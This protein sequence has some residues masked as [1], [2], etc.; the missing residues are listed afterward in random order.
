MMNK[1]EHIS[2]ICVDYTYDGLGLVRSESGFCVFV[3]DM[4]VGEAGDI[5]ITKSR[6]NYAYGRLLTRTAT[7][8][9]RVKPVCPLY[10]QC[11]GCQLQHMSAAEQAEFKQRHVQ[12]NLDTIASTK[13]TAEPVITMADPYHYR[14]KMQMP[15]QTDENGHLQA[16]FYRY[17]SHEIIPVDACLLQNEVTNAILHDLRNLIDQYHIASLIRHI[18]IKT[19]PNTSQAM[20]ALVLWKQPDIDLLPLAEQLAEAQPWVV[21]VISCIND[22]ET[23]V[24]WG[25]DE[26]TVYGRNRITDELMQCRFLISA[27][28]FYQVNSSQTAVL[29]QTALDAAGLKESDT[30]I[31][32][33]CGVGTIGIL[34][35]GRVKKVIGVE[36]VPEAVNDAVQ[37]ARL[38]NLT[39]VEYIC[40]D[41]SQAVIQLEKRKIKPDVVIVDPPRKGCSEDVLQAV[42][43]MSPDRLVYVSCNPATLARD[44]AILIKLGFKVEKVIPVDMF[45]QTMHVETCV[46]LSH[47][48]S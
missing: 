33:Y 30:L 20:V 38:N 1:N 36:I 32:L 25:H 7:S 9:Q 13:I 19:M 31:D 27:H 48:N 18:L 17:N 16:G 26:K 3:K 29:Y 45:P 2:G 8:E 6:K 10:K 4:L 39:N 11:G 34:A 47:K 42:S 22:K 37:N 14:N 24:I 40:A 43:K 28:S 41:A 23:N 35:A 15:A 46:L 21:S 12:Q 44:L 5:I